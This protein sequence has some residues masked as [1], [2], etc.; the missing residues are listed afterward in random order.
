MQLSERLEEATVIPKHYQPPLKN[1]GFATDIK[2][3]PERDTWKIIPH[4]YVN[5][6]SFEFT[7]FHCNSFREETARNAELFNCPFSPSLHANQ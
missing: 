5:I 2:K 6:F 3:L 4:S 7:Y 1:P